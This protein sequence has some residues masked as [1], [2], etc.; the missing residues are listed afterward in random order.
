[1][2]IW[3]MLQF[4]RG[5][6]IVTCEVFDCMHRHCNVYPLLIVVPLQIDATVEVTSSIFNNV[7][8]LSAQG[9]KEVFEFFI[10][11]IFYSKVMDA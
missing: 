3:T 1:M 10:T 6:M 5:W 2:S 9:S 11:N 4:Q 8:G 7:I